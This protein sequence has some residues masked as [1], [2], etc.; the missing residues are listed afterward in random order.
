M[1]PIW[2]SE[3]PDLSEAGRPSS[4]TPHRLPEGHPLGECLFE[5]R[6][7]VESCWRPD[8]LSCVYLHVDFN[9]PVHIYVYEGV[10]MSVSLE[11]LDD[12]PEIVQISHAEHLFIWSLKTYTIFE[13]I[14]LFKGQESLS[15][16]CS[17]THYR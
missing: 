17:C 12:N 16:F 1:T 9:M 3:G 5:V 14:F 8:S 10:C 11:I 6:T 13:D 7:S 4:R 2:Q 15:L